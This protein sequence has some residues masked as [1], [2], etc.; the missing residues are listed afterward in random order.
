[1]FD[2]TSGKIFIVG[3]VCG[4]LYVASAFGLAARAK[5]V[6][7]RNALSDLRTLGQSPR[8]T[9][10]LLNYIFRAKITDGPSR[11]LRA[12]CVVFFTATLALFFLT[13]LFHD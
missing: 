2:D 8:E 4:V 3:W 13:F 9:G 7:P 12:C 10:I 5:A 6:R 1:M 11:V